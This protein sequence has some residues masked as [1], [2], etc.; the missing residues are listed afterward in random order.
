MGLGHTLNIGVNLCEN[1]V[2]LRMD[3]DDIMIKDRVA[4]QLTCMLRKPDMMI[5]GAQVECFRNDTVESTTRHTNLTWDVFKQKPSVWFLNHP[6]V[7]FKKSAVLKVGNYNPLLNKMIEDFDLWLRM[8]KEYKTIYNLDEVLLKYRLHDDQVTN[9]NKTKGQEWQ[10]K[11]IQLIQNIIA[12]D[13]EP[14]RVEELNIEESNVEESDNIVEAE[15]NT[16]T[17]SCDLKSLPSSDKED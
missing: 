14:P 2:I 4:K 12:S 17:S 5:C 7:A 8:L 16:T 3:A 1:E 10:Q 13:Q 6:T 11:R 9:E 15:S